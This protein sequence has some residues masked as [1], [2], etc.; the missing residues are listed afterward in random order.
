MWHVKL[1][2][3]RVRMEDAFPNRGNVI[4]KMTAVMVRMKE[5][6]AVSPVHKNNQI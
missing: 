5:I 3:F 2:N 1:Q 4:L 6:F